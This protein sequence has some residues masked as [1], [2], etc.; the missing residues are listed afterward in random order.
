[1]RVLGIDP[2]FG[3]CGIAVMDDGS[4]SQELLFSTCIETVPSS[5]FSERILEIAKEIEQ[6]IAMF[7]PDAIALEEVFFSKNQKTAIQVAEVRGMILYLA[8]KNS[9]IVTEYNPGRVKVAVTGDGNADKEQVKHMVHRMIRM[10]KR[11][12]LDDE[13]DAI[14]LCVA[15]LSEYRS[16]PS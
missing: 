7:L 12:R 9:I 6:A 11:E 14:A 16:R 5:R 13:Y 1:M 10:D 2:G 4:G 3:R 8:V 15:H